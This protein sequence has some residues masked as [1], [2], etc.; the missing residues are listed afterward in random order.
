MGK[1]VNTCPK[2]KTPLDAM[3][4]KETAFLGCQKCFGLWVAEPDLASYVE[5]GLSAEIDLCDLRPYPARELTE[6]CAN[7]RIHR[8]EDGRA[9]FAPSHLIQKGLFSWSE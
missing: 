4:D 8:G 3:T 2:C 9:G 5:K 6:R 1:D 7:L